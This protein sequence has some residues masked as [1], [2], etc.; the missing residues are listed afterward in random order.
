MKKVR[1][2]FFM[3]WGAFFVICGCAKE[4]QFTAVERIC[5]ADVDKAGAMRAAEEVL[6]QMHFRIEK[7]DAESGYIRSRPLV[8]GQFFEF[9][10]SDNV[11]GFN[12]S[13]ANLHSI[14]RTVELEITEQGGQMCVGC[15]ANVQ[16][17]G[18]PEREVDS[19]AKAY[20]MFSDSERRMQRLELNV[21]QRRGMAWIGLGRDGQLETEILKR[22]EGELKGESA[23]E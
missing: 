16:R 22:I 10:R 14:R 12:W 17:L 19:S 21:E 1:T 7:S 8:G 23:N 9:W 18:L 15:S 2:V 6:G 4:Q 11:G 5:Q 20:A 13:E 3:V